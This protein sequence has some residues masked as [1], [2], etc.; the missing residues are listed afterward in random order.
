MS[1]VSEKEKIKE[2]SMSEAMKRFVMR[3]NYLVKSGYQFKIIM[4][5]VLL[6]ALISLVAVINLYFVGWRVTATITGTNDPSVWHSLIKLFFDRYINLIIGVALIDILV[7]ILLGIL[8]S[9][10]FAGP[11][12]KL[13]NFFL[14]L[15]NTGKAE[16]LQFRKEDN[17]DDLADSVNSFTERLNLI[18]EELK[19]LIKALETDDIKGAKERAALI[20]KIAPEWF[21]VIKSEDKEA[22][23]TA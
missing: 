3:R 8:F 2:S 11:I 20:K 12:H 21:G 10:Q 19:F 9:H 6:F 4:S 1:E 7:V 5:L 22:E 15:K 16:K 14:K 18:T 13:E 23:G 17:L